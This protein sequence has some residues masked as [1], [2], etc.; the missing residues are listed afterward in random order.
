MLPNLNQPYTL[1]G[2]SS[3]QSPPVQPYG[4]VMTS[5]EQGDFSDQEPR[6]YQGGQLQPLAASTAN[7][8]NV[9]P[10]EATFC[11]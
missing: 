5:S 6:G 3:V 8:V 4:G 7:V 10:T 11:R 2:A 9:V 1:D